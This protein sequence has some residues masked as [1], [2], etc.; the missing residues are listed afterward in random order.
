M[1]RDPAALALS[2]ADADD[3]EPTLS[4]DT[5]VVRE[6]AHAMAE[7]D[8]AHRRLRAV[9][10]ASVGLSPL[11][12][13]ALM[14]VG[15]RGDTTPKLLAAHLDITTGAITALTDRLVGA[16]LVGRTPNP[17]DRRS[18]LLSLTETGA[19]ARDTMY[20][21]YHE[22]IA[23]ALQGGTGLEAGDIT[24]L[25]DRTAEAI[26]AT[27]DAIEAVPVLPH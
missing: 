2:A 4:A 12:F 6:I 3:F 17:N 25:L 9:F 20:T 23:R 19:R 24:A 16:G 1:T 14:H 10:A 27:A 22:A 11:E 15:E 8:A 5:P 13:N 26:T 7:T 18:L 21:Q